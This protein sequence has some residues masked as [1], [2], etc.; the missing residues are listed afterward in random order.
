MATETM[1]PQVRALMRRRRAR[2]FVL[3][4]IAV[5]FAALVMGMPSL[6]IFVRAF[7]EGIGA[8]V[9]SINEP[10]TLHAITLTVITALIA[11]PV[12]IVFG[13]C[14]AWA[15]TRFRFPGRRALVTIIELPFS[16]SPIVAGLCYLLVYGSTGLVGGF[17]DQWNIQLMFNLTGIVLVSLFVTCPFVAR[18]LIPLMEIAGRDQEEAALTLG[19]NG[20]QTFFY[21]TLPNIR[22]ALLYG[23]ILANAR[24]IGEF[25]AVS[26]VSGNIRG[27]T[28]TLPLQVQ[29]LYDDYNVT[30]AF[31]AATILAAIAVL[32]LI[33]RS[34]IEARHPNVH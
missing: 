7:S 25:G 32:T 23:A 34:V 11:L 24:V 13:I 10:E 6:A 16:I 31:A 9:A 33:L 28:M 22:W 2:R 27:E 14:A 18:E 15:V 12:N 17:L 26:V 4:I 29:L 19:A 8:Y 20:W 3:V 30:G 5:A 21:V 1:H